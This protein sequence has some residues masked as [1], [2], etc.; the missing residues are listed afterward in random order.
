MSAKNI[1]ILDTE[2]DTPDASPGFLL[3]QVTNSW[4]ARQRSALK[5]FGLTHV[6]FVLLA[7]LAWMRVNQPITQEDLAKHAKTDRMMTS[8]VLRL[9]E[10]KQLI[11]RS[12]HPKDKRAFALSVSSQG[13]RLVN[14]AIIAVEQVDKEFFVQLGTK[15][16]EFTQ[17]LF[18]LSCAESATI[19]FIPAYAKDAKK[20]HKLFMQA[21]K[22]KHKYEDYSW[23]NGFSLDGTKRMLAKDSTFLVLIN[24]NLAGTVA[25]EWNDNAW[26]D[27]QENKAGYIHRLAIADGFHGQ[28][29]GK[30][31]IDWVAKQ[32]AA[33]GR[34][35][36][37]LDC[38]VANSNLC[39]YYENQGFKH[40]AT[41]E[42]P[43]YDDYTAALYERSV[44]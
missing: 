15:T 44:D 33:K 25:L 3:W 24:A 5:P 6:Q 16:Q 31:I 9:L 38:N 19:E 26:E 4:Q 23:Q 27:D 20:L 42:F 28:Q 18:V 36:L 11:N 14:K 22:Y 37:R 43:E 41:K 34:N 7:S 2:F 29:L 32:V 17:N 1:P 10:K 21:A 13:M 35:Y 40:V 39:A 12:K 30:Q 8:E